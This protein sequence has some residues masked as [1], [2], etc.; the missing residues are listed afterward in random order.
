MILNFTSISSF[1]S[2]KPRRHCSKQEKVSTDI[3]IQSDRIH[4]DEI[5]FFSLSQYYE[6]W[7]FLPRSKAEADKATLL[8]STAYRIAWVI[9][10]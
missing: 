2:K 7:R 3:P 5:M 4:Y 10:L 8:C 1:R 6:I 9:L